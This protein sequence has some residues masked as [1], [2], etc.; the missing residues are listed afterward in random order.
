MSRTEVAA[1][2]NEPLYKY[3]SRQV[4]RTVLQ[5]RTLR[6]S[7]PRTLNDPRDMQIDLRIDVDY[8]AMKPLVLQKLWDGHYG[9]TRPEMNLRANWSATVDDSFDRVQRYFF[10]EK[11]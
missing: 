6:W 11:S 10:S 8:A 7:T 4:G 3:M 2:V 9:E 5:N 1:P